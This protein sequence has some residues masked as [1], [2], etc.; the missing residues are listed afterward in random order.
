MR[1]LWNIIART[2]FWSY[3]RGT[4]PYDLMVIAIL[5]FVLLTPRRWFHDQPVLGAAQ[6]AAG[7][8]L[9]EG[10]ADAETYR[11]DAGML[12]PPK[13]TPDLE[14]ET[15]GILSRNVAELKGRMFQITRIE[16]VHADDGTVLGY[17]ISVKPLR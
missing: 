7:I 14:Q 9:L 8:H 13:S 5:V 12:T 4:W 11:I 6:Q 3:E 1:T 15:H 16:P 2:L 10:N 17:D